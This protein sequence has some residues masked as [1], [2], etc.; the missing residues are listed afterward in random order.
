MALNFGDLF[1]RVTGDVAQMDTEARQKKVDDRLDELKE[2]KAFYRRL[3][4]SRF[5]NDEALYTDELKRIASVKSIYNDIAARGLNADDA[6]LEIASKTIPDFGKLDYSIQTR[7]LSNIKSGFKENPN[8]EGFTF[9]HGGMNFDKPNIEDYYK[10]DQYWANLADEIRT[11]TKTK[12]GE[13]FSSLI[14]QNKKDVKPEEYLNS[15]KDVKRMQIKDDIAPEEYTSSGKLDTSANVY[16]AVATLTP[17]PSLRPDERKKLLGEY[18][19]IATVNTSSN[20]E[21][22]AN[23]LESFLPGEELKDYFTFTDGGVIGKNQNAKVLLDQGLSIYNQSVR[24]VFE[25]IY[26]QGGS[27]EAQF[28]LFTP[29]LIMETFKQNLSERLFFAPPGTIEVAGTPYDTEVVFILPADIVNSAKNKGISTGKLMEIVGEKGGY[30]INE[31]EENEERVMFSAPKGSQKDTNILQSGINEYLKDYI[32]QAEGI[33]VSM[34]GI[35][36][37]GDLVSFNQDLDL[38]GGVVVPKGP[39]NLQRFIEIL[40][41]ENIPLD[42]LPKELREA[43][44]QI[45]AGS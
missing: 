37:R 34:S 23:T 10:G 32:K 9:T 5:A 45:K 31:G 18:F 44:E 13:Q 41:K 39:Y 12:L 43:I 40:E 28:T 16:D 17:S 36:I 30:I 35:T 42:K 4:E 25:S 22:V 21:S 26:A 2:Q 19:Q 15:I 6:A 7:Y 33:D 14:G 38:G 3:A 29:E 11:G 20:K 27:R 24:E 1:L 8:G